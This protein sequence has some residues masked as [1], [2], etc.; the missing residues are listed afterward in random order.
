MK[1]SDPLEC[2]NVTASKEIV[3]FN[4]DELW[5]PKLEDHEIIGTSENFEGWSFY[6]SQTDN[7]DNAIKWANNAQVETSL[8]DIY[9]LPKGMV[10]TM[11]SGLIIAH[12]I[13]YVILGFLCL[14]L[15]RI[16]CSAHNGVNI[17]MSSPDETPV[18]FVVGQDDVIVPYSRTSFMN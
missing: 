4:I 7:L 2:A 3:L 13:A 8:S 10:N 17:S 15:Y 11:F 9:D 5:F 1:M 16:C 14:K 18:R 12:L 6:A